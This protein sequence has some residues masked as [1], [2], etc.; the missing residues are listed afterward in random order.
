MK[1]NLLRNNIIK[2]D[3]PMKNF[4]YTVDNSTFRYYWGLNWNFGALEM[5]NDLNRAALSHENPKKKN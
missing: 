4:L 1:I 3:K 5:W 2:I